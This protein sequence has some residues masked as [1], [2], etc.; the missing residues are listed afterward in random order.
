MRWQGN[1]DSFIIRRLLYET[2]KLTIMLKTAIASGLVLG[3]LHGGAAVAGPYVNIESNSGFAGSDYDST[4]LE[5]H[6]GYEDELGEKSSWYIQGGPAIVF[7]DGEDAST[8]LSGKVGLGVDVTDD[9][10]A[11]AEVAVI[12]TEE[13]DLDEGVDSNVKLGVK[14]TF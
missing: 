8:E 3:A 5:N 9:L 7:A 1:V 4:L 10:S 2:N 14:Y 13:I 6:I 12:T 11:Y